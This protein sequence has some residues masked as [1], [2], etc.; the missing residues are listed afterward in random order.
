LTSIGGFRQNHVVLLGDINFFFTRNWG[1]N[2]RYA[3][4]P[5]NIRTDRLFNPY[6]F[7]IRALFAL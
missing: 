5:M 3:R 4:A 2:L 7:S 6:M 1:V